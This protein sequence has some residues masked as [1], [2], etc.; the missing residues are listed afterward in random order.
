MNKMLA[1]VVT[2]KGSFEVTNLLF[3]YCIQTKE[4]IMA[5]NIPTQTGQ[6][7]YLNIVRII[8]LFL[9]L[10]AHLVTVACFAPSLP[11]VFANPGTLPIID[12]ATTHIYAFDIWLQRVCH[13][14]CGPLGVV[15]FLLLSGYLATR[16]R[17]RYDNPDFFKRRVIRLWPG[18]V[19]SLTLGA[20]VIMLAGGV[21]VTGWQYFFNILLLYPFFSLP[22]I[23]GVVWVLIVEMLCH[24][25]LIPFRH[26]N[27]KNISIIN[28]IVMIM[29]LF[30]ISTGNSS[31]QTM[32]Y[33]LRFVP[34]MLFGCAMSKYGFQSVKT[35]FLGLWSFVILFLSTK[36]IFPTDVHYQNINTYLLSLGIWGGAYLACK[37]IKMPKINILGK[38]K[39][40]LINTSYIV[41]LIHV[42]VGFT[43][44]YHMR[45]ILPP[46]TNIV[47]TTLMVL[48]IAT[49]MHY[50]IEKPISN[51]LNKKFLAK[52]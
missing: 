4:Q 40:V 19:L 18:L 26:I 51:Y 17:E 20:L 44:M 27:I 16:S 30:Q 3:G 39:R 21:K 7:E 25:I 8:A 5:D 12:N 34:L 24:V 6:I 23:T 45:G 13:T 36:Y 48:G 22:A 32:L 49:A 35:I 46:V 41:Y 38:I 52:Q 2:F 47:A 10:Y 29:L 33:Y 11:E 50:L 31:N 28:A 15:L 1:E 37:D 42:P 9:I 14:A 43:I